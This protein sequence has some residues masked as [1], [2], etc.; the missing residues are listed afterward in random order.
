MTADPTDSPEDRAYQRRV[1]CIG[2]L[3]TLAA[4]GIAACFLYPYFSGA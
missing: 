4:A 2:A 3:I 1:L